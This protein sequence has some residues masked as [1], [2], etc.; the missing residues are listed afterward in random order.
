MKDSV[1][2]LFRQKLQS[3]EAT[4][5][6]HAWDQIQEKLEPKKS[7]N[8]WYYVAAAITAIVSVSILWVSQQ[9]DTPSLVAVEAISNDEKTVN[10]KSNYDRVE[11]VS[12]ATSSVIIADPTP[13]L[14][15]GM[16]TIT[17]TEP[18][19][20]HEV[21]AK[22]LLLKRDPMLSMQA[23][24]AKVDI[25]YEPLQLDFYPMY[26]DNLVADQSRFKKAVQYVQ[27]VKNGEENLFNLR[28][29]KENLF[30]FAKSKIKSEENSQV[31]F[32]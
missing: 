27:R 15:L 21:V 26:V 1:D 10:E 22:P 17:Q 3:L 23:G 14:E 28:K 9:V 16:N 25:E 4:P 12:T 7:M 30:A 8:S 20:D 31:N 19:L 18:V 24:V 29:A 5:S 13:E 2:K 11:E 32:D 6:I